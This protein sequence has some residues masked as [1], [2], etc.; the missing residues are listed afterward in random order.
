MLKL[1]QHEE[2][3][4]H[5]EQTSAERRLD[6]A[7]N[8]NLGVFAIFVLDYCHRQIHDNMVASSKSFSN[9]DED[10]A[11][12]TQCIQSSLVVLQRNAPSKEMKNSP[13]T[14][15]AKTECEHFLKRILEL[16]ITFSNEAW[17]GKYVEFSVW[18]FD[19]VN[20]LQTHFTTHGFITKIFFCDAALDLMKIASLM[21]ATTLD[22]TGLI[23]KEKLVSFKTGCDLN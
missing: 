20:V 1:L 17:N 3:G 21:R 8:T 19:Q 10:I 15:F 14:L 9:V 23:S 16:A 12:V 22:K 6:N 7:S 4:G 18:L 11:H 5:D 13:D 2:N